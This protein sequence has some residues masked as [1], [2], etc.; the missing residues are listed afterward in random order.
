MLPVA[1]DWDGDTKEGHDSL[2]R[3][4]IKTQRDF[5]G[6]QRVIRVIRRQTWKRPAGGQ[7]NLDY[8]EEELSLKV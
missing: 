3:R 5:W 1:I 4:L 6:F 8:V 7:T 2:P